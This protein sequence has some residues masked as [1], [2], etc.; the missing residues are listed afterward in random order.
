[1]LLAA[2]NGARYLPEQLASFATQT[3][4]WDLW[5]RDDGSTDETIPLLEPLGTRVQAASRLGAL[6][7][8]LALLRAATPTLADG[9][10][11]AFSDQDDV[12]LPEKLARGAAAL[13]R[14]GP[15]RPAI[16]TARQIYTDA[17]GRRLGQSPRVRPLGFPASL[18]QN[19]AVGCATMLNASAARLV[20]ASHPPPS[21]FHD[22]WSYILVTAAGGA[23][24][25]DAEPGVLYR[26]HQENLT[27]A[28][29]GWQR[30]HHALRRGPRPYMDRMRDHLRALEANAGLISP[31]A[32]V[33]AALLSE[34][35]SGDWRARKKA[36]ATQG[37]RRQ[38]GLQTMLFR[39]WF[40][41]G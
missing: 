6:G 32:R 27:G 11:V 41:L 23:C 10:A 19:I 40:L 15:G 30:A 7:S 16:Y 31:E 33:T 20:A 1:M 8:F 39:L 22:W 9:D 35:L 13:G 5:W 38:T 4:P 3:H 2:R 14:V 21:A 25:W 37:L 29:R 26:Q 28:K 18:T 24:L 34:A 17:G 36:L 12:W